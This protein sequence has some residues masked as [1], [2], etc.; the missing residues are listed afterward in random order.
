M[1]VVIL[2]MV[3]TLGSASLAERSVGGLSRYGEPLY[4]CRD[5]SYRKK[6]GEN[7]SNLDGRVDGIPWFFNVSII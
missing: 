3:Y 1:D 5:I 7:T 2:K 4:V 6:V